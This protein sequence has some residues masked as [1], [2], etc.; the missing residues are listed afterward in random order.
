VAAGAW[1]QRSGGPGNPQQL[2]RYSYVLNNPVRGTDPSGHCGGIT[3]MPGDCPGENKDAW[4]AGGRAI[5]GGGSSSGGGGSWTGQVA[6]I[7]L[8]ETLKELGAAAMRNPVIRGAIAGGVGN[9]ISAAILEGPTAASPDQLQ[10][11]VT[12]S[13][14]A[15]ATGGIASVLGGPLAGITVTAVT[16]SALNGFSP[17]VFSESALG[18][19]YASLP[20][21]LV[22]GSLP[23]PA[24]IAMV[25]VG[26][27]L[28]SGLLEG[29]KWLS[30][31]TGG[32][33]PAPSREPLKP[34]IP[35]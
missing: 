22:S 27:M 16:N 32:D 28:G 2:N 23:I 17:R 15:G 3:D 34:R 8:K 18:E 4:V 1:G 19:T 7:F 9:G 6:A 21:G 13:T 30:H 14:V 25:A 35:R 33:Q 24:E 10:T 31:A 12:N 11:R 5:G 20:I 26:N 29:T